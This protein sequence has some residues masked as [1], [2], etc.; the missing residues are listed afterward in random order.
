VAA[1]QVD[2]NAGEAAEFKSSVSE[3]K[4][5]AHRMI[6]DHT[7]AIKQA[8]ALVTK[9]KVTAEEDTLSKSI[10]PDGEKNLDR[11]NKMD[12]KESLQ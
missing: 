8:T 11:L 3:V 12:G 10:R 2:I 1:N 4:A 7:D 9:L 6:A 5:F